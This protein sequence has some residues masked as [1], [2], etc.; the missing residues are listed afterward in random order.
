MTFSQVSFLSPLLCELAT[1]LTFWNFWQAP[2]S[3]AI[4]DMKAK[5]CKMF[6]DIKQKMFFCFHAFAAQGLNATYA[7]VELQIGRKSMVS[8]AEKITD[9][10]FNFFEAMDM[11]DDYAYDDK[12]W[13]WHDSDYEEGWF[14]SDLID[15]AVPVCWLRVWRCN[16]V[17]NA[18]G[19]NA[20]QFTRDLVGFKRMTLRELLNIG[21]RSAV[22][23]TD[24]ACGKPVFAEQATFDNEK[25]NVIFNMK[26]SSLPS[27]FVP[28]AEKPSREYNPNCKDV[29]KPHPSHPPW[30]YGKDDLRNNK[31]PMDP[32]RGM[33]CVELDRDATCNLGVFDHAGFVWVSLKMYV[34]SR[35]NC[36]TPHRGGPPILSPFTKYS[37]IPIPTPSQLKC[38]D[39][40][41]LRVHVYQAKDLPSV[42]AT[43][44]ANAFVQ[45]RFKGKTLQ[46][47]T[48]YGSNSPTWDETLS[49]R[50]FNEIE[51]PCLGWPGMEG[52]YDTDPLEFKYN[53]KD[54]DWEY[55]P[56]DNPDKFCERW[57]KNYN[58]LR[59][60]PR[61]EIR[62]LESRG[63]QKMLL[64]RC[65]VPPEL[66]FHTQ[67]DPQVRNC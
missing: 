2:P 36:A 25:S 14:P 52:E 54:E 3:L 65:F 33:Q 15:C 11:E 27:F 6:Q 35:R 62:V 47:H 32:Y 10:M 63:G 18:V 64:G 43:G 23:E 9:G 22:A 66:C 5:D 41:G 28:A 1:A 8:K 19:L 49:G 44:L 59:L 40:F 45:V 31:N 55:S 24:L 34:P 13:P 48:V 42:N 61:I 38:T 17:A 21:E 53:P 51:L 20:L 39:Y 58:M 46:T 37:E 60:A 29:F 12:M 4:T 67:C 7:Q 50:G 26:E 30:P 16:P 56:D 57:M